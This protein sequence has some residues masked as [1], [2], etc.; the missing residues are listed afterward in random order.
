MLSPKVQGLHAHTSVRRQQTCSDGHE[1]AR[2]RQCVQW[3][4][5]SLQHLLNGLDAVCMCVG[6]CGGC[7]GGCYH[8]F[9]NFWQSKKQ[10]KV[11]N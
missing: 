7:G 6:V 5:R 9:S 1:K 10:F 8:M 4:V 2:V 11:G 3:S